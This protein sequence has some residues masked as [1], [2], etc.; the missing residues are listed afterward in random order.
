MNFDTIDNLPLHPLVV[1]A[2][3]VLIPLVT[4]GVLIASIKPSWH[5]NFSIPIF[6]I[7]GV[8]LVT[9]KLSEESGQYLEE[10]VKES[11]YLED[12]IE[13]GQRF[14][15]IAFLLMIFI[16][17]WSAYPFV[18]DGI[19]FL[20]DKDKVTRISLSVIAVAFALYSSFAVY[21]VGH[22]GAKSVW[23]DTPTTEAHHE[24]PG[25]TDG[26]HD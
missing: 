15:V 5:K 7:A 6:L 9:A 18:K 8:A 16:T 22:S 24:L 3:I 12:H 19:A 25:T 11:K 14:F 2:T 1:H 17:L 13:L 10:R 20:K 23:H 4:L 26:D 21:E